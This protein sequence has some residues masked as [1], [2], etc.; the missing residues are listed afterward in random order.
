M[1]GLS[2][3]DGGSDEELVASNAEVDDEGAKFVVGFGATAAA[4]AVIMW[5]IHGFGTTMR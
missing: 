4:R 1:L 3:R 2:G 5:S